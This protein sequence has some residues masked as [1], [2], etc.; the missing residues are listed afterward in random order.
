M[1]IHIIKDKC[2]LTLVQIVLIGKDCILGFEPSRE[3]DNR[4]RDCLINAIEVMG[5]EVQ[6]VKN[7]SFTNDDIEDYYIFFKTSSDSLFHYELIER[8]NRAVAQ[9][10]HRGTKIIYE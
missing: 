6:E 10:L 7:G 5:G 1:H 9:F 2:G 8:I 4:F 3:K